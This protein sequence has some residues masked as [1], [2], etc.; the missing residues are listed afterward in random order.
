LERIHPRSGKKDAAGFGTWIKIFPETRRPLAQAASKIP[1]RDPR[2]GRATRRGAAHGYGERK[3]TV[4]TS[5]ITLDQ[6][7]NLIGEAYTGMRRFTRLIN[8]F[9]KKVANHEAPVALHFMHYNFCR[10]HQTLRC[11]PAMAAKV[12]DHVWS[13]EEVV[14]LLD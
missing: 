14:G 4:L 2:T 11:T 6:V 7:Q 3:P 5:N 10:I 9:S 1:G 13:V 8:G 12:A